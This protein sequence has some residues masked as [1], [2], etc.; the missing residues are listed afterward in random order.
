MDLRK[1]N[2]TCNVPIPQSTIL[3]HGQPTP[4]SSPDGY[5]YPHPGGVL[6]EYL[7][8]YEY[9]GGARFRGF[10]AEKG[11][12][13]T[14]FIFFDQEVIEMD[15]KQG[16]VSLLELASSEHFGCDQLVVGIDR[17]ADEDKVKDL[18]RDLGWVG[19]ELSMLDPWTNGEGCVS[20]RFI[21]LA[22]DV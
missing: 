10:V 11:D 15:L 4:S 19:F 13:R 7:E 8:V 16:L 5:D 3:Q 17:E 9:A 21:L 12:M 18:S 22:M 2:T 1:V 6:K 20:E 14:M